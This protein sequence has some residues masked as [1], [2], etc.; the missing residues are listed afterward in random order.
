MSETDRPTRILAIHAHPDDVELQCFGTLA[1][2]QSR[3]CEIT[4]ATMT[5][6]DKG[7]DELSR[8]EISEVRRG[9]ARAAADLIS[10]EYVC[11]EFQDLEI[12]VDNLSRRRVT[13]AIR[14]ARPDIVLTAPPVDYMSDH[15]MTSRLVRDACFA[16]PA[17]NFETEVPSA[18]PPLERIPHLYYVDA[19]EHSDLFGQPLDPDFIVDVGETYDLKWKSFACHESQRQW[20]LRQHGMDD[21]M[22]ALEKW[23]RKRGEEAGVEFGEGFKQHVG[24]PYPHDNLLLELLK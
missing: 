17:P 24:H 3:G 20:L 1:L 2:L 22:T 11:L 15:E 7:S 16:A 18:A 9:E 12:V 13:E 6:G 14:R 8:H 4:I 23:C 10:A 19:V 21:Y 5:P